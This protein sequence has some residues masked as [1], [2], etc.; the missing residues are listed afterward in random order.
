M[1]NTTTTTSGISIAAST[2]TSLIEIPVMYRLGSGTTTFG[3]GGFYGLVMGS[4]G[5][6]NYGL[7]AG[8]RFATAGGLF[9]D[10]RFNYALK[11]DSP[12]DVLAMIGYY[13]GK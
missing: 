7:T 11:T 10:L 2:N 9:L 6:S 4:G 13:F 1:I 5:G 3:L 12:K 8:P